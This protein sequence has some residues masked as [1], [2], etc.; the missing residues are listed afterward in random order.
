VTL[1][2]TQ[3]LVAMHHGFASWEQLRKHVR[4][5]RI[6]N[7]NSPDAVVQHCAQDIPACAGAGVPLGGAAALPG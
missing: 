5:R 4:A 1:N 6:T 3:F 7:S 2:E